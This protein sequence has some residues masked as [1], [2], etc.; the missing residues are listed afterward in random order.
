MHDGVRSTDHSYRKKIDEKIA[1]L[2]QGHHGF[3]EVKGS[4]KQRVHAIIE[5][6]TASGTL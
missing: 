2:A 3:M 6:L 5:S 4:R 1:L